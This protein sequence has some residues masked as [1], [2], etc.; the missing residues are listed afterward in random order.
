SYLA[1]AFDVHQ[2][3]FRHLMY[4]EYKA[5]R[6]PMPDD[7][8]VQLPVLKDVLTAMGIKICELPGYEAD[9]VIGTI[10]KKFNVQTYIYT[11]D[12]DAYQL[13]D[14]TTNVCFTRKGVSDILELNVENFQDEV[15]LT[16]PQIIDFKAL[17]GD[18]SDHIPGVAGIGEKSA[19]QL[20]E[21]Y[22]TLD[23][24]Y[25]H[26]DEIGGAVQR[27][28]IEGK[29]DAYFSYRLATIKTDSPVEIEIAD[30]LAPKRFSAAL[31]NKFAE[32]EFKS[33][34]GMDIFEEEEKTENDGGVSALNEPIVIEKVMESVA[35]CL[36]VLREKDYEAVSCVWL[37]NGFKF[38]LKETHDGKRA[39]TELTEYY[40]PIK[41]GLLDVGFYDY[42][43]IA[44]LRHIFE[45]EKPVI[46]YASKDFRRKLYANDV[47]FTAPFEDVSILKCLA[48]G[49]GNSDG[50]EFCLNYY[51]LPAS[52]PAYG[53]FRLWEIYSGKLTDEE[54]WLYKHVELPLSKVLF[55]MEL[56]GVCVDERRLNEFSEKY[57]TEIASLTEEIYR[58]AGERFNVNS[59]QQLGAVLFD[60]LQIG[61]GMKKAKTTRS[62]KTTA[63]ELEKYASEHPIIGVILRYRQAQKLNS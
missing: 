33:L 18:K 63:E 62:Y 46:V 54:S 27:K 14:G 3:T 1:V 15:G 36:T 50:L 26:I 58:L 57:N 55:D 4:D 24:I 19:R 52:A 60:K 42:E 11:G 47:S 35:E 9:D 45:G 49:L 25:A 8:V 53:T 48:D 7:L 61:A 59:T 38:F 29:E 20:L 22:E 21:N 5:G 10:A 13:V 39:V 6:K 28:L 34:V 31:R 30:C 2:P 44:V 43:L 51:A 12:R 32:L 40:C 37:E 41:L 23:G 16:P 56:Q 17:M